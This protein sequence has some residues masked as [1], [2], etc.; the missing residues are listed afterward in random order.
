MSQVATIESVS[1]VERKVR[2]NAL[3]NTQRYLNTQAML[4]A[5]FEGADV[6]YRIH[7]DCDT[8]RVEGFVPM[9]AGDEVDARADLQLGFFWVAF[10]RAAFRDIG[11]AE[12]IGELLTGVFNALRDC[13]YEKFTINPE[14]RIIDLTFEGE[15]AEKLINSPVFE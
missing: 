1:L 12:P 4:P 14:K 3:S 2:F 10:G 15:L 6:V 8:V 11:V 7:V 9:A 5:K 13:R